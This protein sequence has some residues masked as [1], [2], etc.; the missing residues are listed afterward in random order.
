VLAAIAILA[1][2]SLAGRDDFNPGQEANVKYKLEYQD[3]VSGDGYVMIWEDINTN[4]LSLLQYAHGSGNIVYSDTLNAQQKRLHRDYPYNYYINSGGYFTQWGDN[5][6][7]IISYKKQTAATQAP[8]SFAY[9]TGWYVDHPVQYNSLLKDKTESKS[10]QEG[11]SMHHLLDYTR[12]YKGDIAVDLNC[13][14]ATEKAVGRGLASMRIEDEVTQGKV[15]VGELFTQ[16]LKYIATSSLGKQMDFK[17]QGWKEPKAEIDANY[18]GNFHIIKNMKVEVEKP[19]K[20]D[21]EDWL[22]CCFGGFFD[23]SDYDLGAVRGPYKDE[24]GIFDCTCRNTSL[25]SYQPKWNGTA[26]QFPTD[27]YRLKP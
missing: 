25:S 8:T 22:G 17:I 19:K 20:S 2:T 5:A 11:I 12:A 23:I 16:G 4:N 9:G 26:A 27:Q 10:Y 13:T 15:H 1:G 24:K 18:I 7:S 6:D 3:D 14:G 21:C